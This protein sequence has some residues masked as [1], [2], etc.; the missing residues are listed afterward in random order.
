MGN[1]IAAGQN[2][3]AFA[4]T[5]QAT[6]AQRI[7]GEAA[8]Q[9]QVAQTQAELAQQATV[10]NAMTA[11][12]SVLKGVVSTGS[13]TSSTAQQQAATTS[14]QQTTEQGTKTDMSA[15]ANTSQ[16]TNTVQETKLAAIKD[17]LEQATGVSASDMTD[18]GKLGVLG[19][20]GSDGGLLGGTIK[21]FGGF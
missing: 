17:I 15:T 7:S 8:M 3:G 18:V 10:A 19:A 16:S 1:V 13:E 4:G 21:G 2:K 6:A 11:L 20:F 14:N 5:P 12:Q 9:G